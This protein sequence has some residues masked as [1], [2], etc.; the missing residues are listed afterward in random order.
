MKYHVF[1]YD[2]DHGDVYA[3]KLEL[4]MKNS[5][6][7]FHSAI[8]KSS[9]EKMILDNI[10]IKALARSAEAVIITNNDWTIIHHNVSA[11]HLL[12]N[13]E[14]NGRSIYD[15]FQEKFRSNQQFSTHNIEKREELTHR[16]L[17]FINDKNHVSTIEASIHQVE[18]ENQIFHLFLLH[19][20]ELAFHTWDQRF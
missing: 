6:T 18:Y 2:C 3:T 5:K 9:L 16:H 20:L 11:Q 10:W 12:K 8:E 17:S 13:D 7:E 14:L 1:D 4:T 19:S 15:F